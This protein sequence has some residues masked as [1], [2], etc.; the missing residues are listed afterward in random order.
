MIDQKTAFEYAELL[1]EYV[2][3]GNTIS[4]ICACNERKQVMHFSYSIMQNPPMPQ[5]E[6]QIDKSLLDLD[7]QKLKLEEQK[8]IIVEEE[9]KIVVENEKP[10]EVNEETDTI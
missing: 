5:T 6:E 8:A 1:E 10:L 7:N 3:A 2:K 4:K 9:K